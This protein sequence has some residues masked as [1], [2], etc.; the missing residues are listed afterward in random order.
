MSRKGLDS[1]SSPRS[2]RATAP[3]NVESHEVVEAA[4]VVLYKV[5]EEK[6]WVLVGVIYLSLAQA[7][8]HHSGGRLW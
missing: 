2:K 8:V 4:E 7:A 5:L 1:S 3:A 6:P